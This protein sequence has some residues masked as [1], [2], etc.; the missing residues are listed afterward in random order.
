MMTDTHDIPV[1]VPEADT[2]EMPL[3]DVY[4]RKQALADGVLVQV[5]QEL[6]KEAGI[7]YPVA[8]TCAVHAECLAVPE[9][10]VG[11][12][13]T[14]RLWDILWMFRC[15]VNRLFAK[16]PRKRQYLAFQDVFTFSLHVR[17]DNRERTPPLVRL[18]AVCGPGDDGEPVI[19]IMFPNED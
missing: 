17:N 10:V 13:E 9:G 19:T 16:F 14:G 12:D 2:F 1:Q 7:R 15:A 11:Q 3:I 4:T 18:K 8:L 6:S 5:P